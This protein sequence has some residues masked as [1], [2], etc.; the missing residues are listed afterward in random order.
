METIKFNRF[1]GIAAVLSATLYLISISGMLVYF[2]GDLSQPF[3][4]ASHIVEHSVMMLVYGWPGIVATV[5]IFPI[6]LSLNE[7]KG[8]ESYFRF[9]KIISLIGLSFV[10]IGYLFQLALTYYITP[11]MVNNPS[12]QEEFG[13]FIQGVIGVQDMFWLNGDLLSFLGI[14]I[15]L[16]LGLK[17]GQFPVWLSI[18]GFIAGFSAAIGSFS[19]IPELKTSILGYF[20]LGGFS[21][22]AMWEIIAGIYLFQSKIQAND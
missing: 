14:G 11:I 9:I 13:L 12:E 7:A 2:E 10:L 15:L 22:F 3:L 20:F 18:L 17:N 4:F 19:F 6:L 21:L 5:L 1:A 8:Y 16:L